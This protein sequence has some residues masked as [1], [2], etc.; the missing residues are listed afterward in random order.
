MERREVGSLGGE[1]SETVKAW[2][3]PLP[4]RSNDPA[5]PV[6]GR[7]LTGAGGNVVSSHS[8]PQNK[9]N[10]QQMRRSG[11]LLVGLPQP[12]NPFVSHRNRGTL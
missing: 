1:D 12:E 5:T 9:K 2:G 4:L 7:R 6:P 8:K 3:A 10:R 11:Q